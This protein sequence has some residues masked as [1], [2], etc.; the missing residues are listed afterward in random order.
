MSLLGGTFF[1]REKR[2]RLKNKKKLTHVTARTLN[3]SRNQRDQYVRLLN[4]LTTPHLTTNSHKA[5][6]N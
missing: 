2:T 1:S 6:D 3:S 4:D 5:R